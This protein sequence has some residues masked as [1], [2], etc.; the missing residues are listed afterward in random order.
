VQ[1]KNVPDAFIHSG[2]ERWLRVRGIEALVIVGVSTNNSVEA[3][4]RSA[5]NLGLRTYVLAD[6]CFAFDKRDYHGTLRSADDVHAMALANLQDEYAEILD[7]RQ[8]LAL[9]E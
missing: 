3:T 6:A 4:A 1:E 5:G 9:L 7:S 8:A 2:L